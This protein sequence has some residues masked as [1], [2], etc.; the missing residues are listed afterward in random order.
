MSNL[1]ESFI[2]EEI[3]LVTKR[4]YIV[5]L[6]SKR[7]ASLDPGFDIVKSKNFFAQNLSVITGLITGLLIATPELI[8]D[9]QFRSA[10]KF[11]NGD[12][13]IA[14]STEWPQSMD[15]INLTA[16]IFLENGFPNQASQIAN[17]GI[18]YQVNDIK[19]FQIAMTHTSY[20]KKD[21]TNGKNF[22]TILYN[23]I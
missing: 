7:V 19:L 8:K 15:R 10:I 17:Y 4:E 1:S 5:S 14:L 16:G 9:A 21:L 22:K 13:I 11:G 18:E 12:K 6:F 23:I 20:I 2:K 3:K